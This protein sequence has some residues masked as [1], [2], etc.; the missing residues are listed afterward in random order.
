MPQGQAGQVDSMGR[1]ASL[2]QLMANG[3]KAH[4]QTGPLDGCH[5]CQKGVPTEIPSDSDVALQM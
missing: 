1:P 3:D 2:S 4:Q 5:Q